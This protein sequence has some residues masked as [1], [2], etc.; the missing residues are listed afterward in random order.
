[1]G[2]TEPNGIQL[3]PSPDTAWTPK[4]HGMGDKTLMD[5]ATAHC[6]QPQSQII[7]RYRLYLQVISLY[8]IITY[9]GHTIYPNIMR[10]EC[11]L[12]R[13]SSIY[14]VD[15]RRPPKKHLVIWQ[16]FLKE[17]IILLIDHMTIQWHP[18]IKPNFTH[19]FSHSTHDN[20]LYQ[21]MP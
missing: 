10:G 15:F 1:M 18:H 19:T 7:N 14:W 6:I 12:S 16:I 20:L 21:S 4:P 3:R 2:E 9:D 11:A 17:H 8:N 5:I 13:H